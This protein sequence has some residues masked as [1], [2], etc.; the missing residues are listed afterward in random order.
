MVT[1]VE[2]LSGLK[3]QMAYSIFIE[4]WRTNNTDAYTQN[5]IRFT[6]GILPVQ[7]SL[8]NSYDI[9]GDVVN[10]GSV[11]SSIRNID[12]SLT[13]VL[14]GIDPTLHKGFLNS[15]VKG[16]KVEINRF[17][18]YPNTSTIIT[19]LEGTNAGTSGYFLGYISTYGISD[20]YDF[21]GGTSS[22]QISVSC[23]SYSSVFQKL[24][25]GMRTNP[26]DLRYLTRSDASGPDSSFDRIPSLSESTFVWGNKK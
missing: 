14:D 5:I 1:A 7:D 3:I 20:S 13:F 9:V 25:K 11:S 2:S 23:N 12:N 22:T 21:N 24:I 19:D 8:G 6:D 17:F 16:A 10:I 15:K 26:K 4:E 18:L